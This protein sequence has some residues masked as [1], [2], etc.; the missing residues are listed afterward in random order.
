[1]GE[2]ICLI[3]CTRVAVVAEVSDLAQAMLREGVAPLVLCASTELA[4]GLPPEVEVV[5]MHG[6]RIVSGCAP[7]QPIG[8]G[9]ALRRLAARFGPMRGAALWL[10]LFRLGKA[11]RALLATRKPEAVYV[12]DDR[13]DFLEMVLLREARR[14]GLRSILVPYAASTREARLYVRAGLRECE[15]NGFWRMI[16]RRIAP[17]QLAYHRGR[18]LLF[19]PPWEGLALGL[20]GLLGHDPW[21]LGDGASDYVAVF[22]ESDRRGAIKDGV[23]T[24]KLVVTGQPSMD[25]MWRTY[26]DRMSLRADLA[27]RYK[28]PTS[29]PLIVCAVPHQAEENLLDVDTHRRDTERLFDVLA[30]IRDSFDGAVLLSLHPKSKAEDY[31]AVAGSRGLMLA[32]ERLANILP[33]ATLFVATYSSTVRWAVLMH[34]PVVVIDTLRRSYTLFDHLPSVLTVTDSDALRVSLER[35]L[36]DEAYYRDLCDAAQRAA[37]LIAPFDGL[38]GRRLITLANR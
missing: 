25:G 26:Q 35:L 6:R 21:I 10:R 19:F 12:F 11:M 29:G 36:D 31:Q 16:Y 17:A 33:A 5:D 9:T 2:P 24:A 15:A 23:P 27:A 38:S 30:E 8:G 7:K 13:G 28:L 37:P 3:T 18:T 14:A 32:E 20:H 4:S 34:I 1:M 22:G